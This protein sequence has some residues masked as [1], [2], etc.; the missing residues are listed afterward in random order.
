MKKKKKKKKKNKTKKK[1][2][3]IISYKVIFFF[4]KGNMNDINHICQIMNILTKNELKL[5]ILIYSFLFSYL[6]F[7]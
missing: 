5:L 3:Q 4:L 2:H 6:L 1:K 7:S